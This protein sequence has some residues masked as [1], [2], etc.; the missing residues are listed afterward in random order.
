MRIL[1]EGLLGGF[2]QNIVSIGT[3]GCFREVSFWQETSLQGAVS[4]GQ[5]ERIETGDLQWGLSR[6]QNGAV[7]TSVGRSVKI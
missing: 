1:I 5:T 2:G 3:I 6:T 4:G 7:G